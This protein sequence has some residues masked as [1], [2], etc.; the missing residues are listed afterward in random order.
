VSGGTQGRDSYSPAELKLAASFSCSP[1]RASKVLRGRTSRGSG[2]T[3]DLQAGFRV[4]CTA[5]GV[6]RSDRPSRRKVSHCIRHDT[7]RG[8]RNSVLSVS[9]LR[10]RRAVDQDD[11]SRHPSRNTAAQRTLEA[12]VA[13][14]EA[15]PKLRSYGHLANSP[16]SPPSNV[17]AGLVVYALA[18]LRRLGSTFEQQRP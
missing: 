5:C 6:T 8:R 16:G 17:I 10:R 2:T 12:L 18:R 14:I 3:D 15:A 7:L 11:T 9:R 13:P 1:D 4:H